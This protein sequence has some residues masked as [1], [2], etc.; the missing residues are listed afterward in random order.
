MSKFWWYPW[1]DHG[2][3]I[4]WACHHD[5]S[6]QMK[7]AKKCPDCGYDGMNILRH[8]KKNEIRGQH[9]EFKRRV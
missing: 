9:N 6:T 5:F 4:C 2:I 7:N 8:I 1:V 3:I